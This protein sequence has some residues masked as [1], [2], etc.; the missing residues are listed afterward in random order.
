MSSGLHSIPEATEKV[1][2]LGELYVR[3]QL[4][5]S[6]LLLSLATSNRNYSKS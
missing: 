6:S 1:A 5:A 2:A 4:V 3:M